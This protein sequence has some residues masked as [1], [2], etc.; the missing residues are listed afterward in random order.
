MDRYG[1]DKPDLRFGMEIRDVS[2]VFGSSGFKVFKETLEKGGV[3]Q[4]P[5]REG[6][7]SF[8]RKELDELTPFVETYGAKGLAWAKVGAGGWQS[9]IQK[10]LVREEMKQVEGRYEAAKGNLFSSS[11]IPPGSSIRPLETSTSI[12]VR[13]LAELA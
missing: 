3:D 11:P 6:R 13:S 4:G 12:S 9:P 1:V 2:G 10:F 8:S 5:L 7:E